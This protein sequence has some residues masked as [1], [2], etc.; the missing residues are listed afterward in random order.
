MRSFH[1][2][3]RLQITAHWTFYDALAVVPYL[4]SLGF[5]SLYLSPILTAKRGS[6]HCYDMTNPLMIN[7]DLGGEEGFRALV[8]AAHAHSMC[9]IVDVVANHMAA[10]IENPWWRDV[11]E[12]GSSSRFSSFFDID[13]KPP[14]QELQGKIL[15]PYL[16]LPF[17][18][19]LEEGGIKMNLREEG[20]CIEAGF[21]RL[22]CNPELYSRILRRSS[23]DKGHYRE[24]EQLF[25]R[26]KKA[27]TNEEKKV[28]AQLIA[29]GKE[30]IAKMVVEHSQEVIE[31]LR[32]INEN[33]T[34]LT[35]FLENQYYRLEYWQT[36][37][38]YINYRR[39]F[40]INELVALRAEENHVFDLC[41]KKLLE[42]CNEGL[43]DGIRVDHPDGLRDPKKYFCRLKEGGCHYL[44]VEKILERNEPLRKDWTVEGT[45]G[46]EYLNTLFGLFV[47]SKS[48]Q[49]MTDL[50]ERFLGEKIDPVQLLIRNKREYA[51]KYMSAEIAAM[52]KKYTPPGVSKEAFILAL[53]DLFAVFPIYRTYI[54]E[55]ETDLLDRKAIQEA[56]EQFQQNSDGIPQKIIHFLEEVFFHGNEPRELLYR[57]QQLSPPIMAKGLEDTHLYQYNRLLSLNEVG[58]SPH[59][60]GFSVDDFHRQ[61]IDGATHFPMRFTTANTHDTKR[62]DD[63]R[64][65][66]ACLSECPAEWEALVLFLSEE[67]SRYS[68]GKRIDKNLEYFFYQTLVGIIPCTPMEVHEELVARVTNYML[69]AAREAKVYT[70]WIN[71]DEN[72]E[73]GLAFFVTSLFTDLSTPFWKRLFP[74]IQKCENAVS[75][76]RISALL[77]RLGSPGVFELYQGTELPFF[78]LVDPDN[79]TPVDYEK[80]RQILE[81]IQHKTHL[82]HEHEKRKLAYLTKFLH[83]RKEHPEL[84]ISGEYMP[85]QCTN[86]SVIGFLR[87]GTKGSCMVLARRFFLSDSHYEGALVHL[88]KEFSQKKWRDLYTKK[89]HSLE[90]PFLVK[91]VIHENPATLLYSYEH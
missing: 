74:F 10:S 5:E 79:R 63:V 53:I 16:P 72:Y 76:S 86:D 85:L 22:P 54:T 15:V 37:F 48:E 59:F 64:L 87:R 73:R 80:R 68:T 45:V 25:D 6:T 38:Q 41:H 4:A 66:I 1:S 7:P 67:A 46:Y 83:F 69:K 62:S 20:I 39:F 8:K 81:E 52:A 60:F 18:Q 27:T 14:H 91:E 56:F 30:Y 9:I 33:K 58:G 88:P 65:R 28:R 12:N 42:L 43:I 31:E 75:Q 40:D 23:L 35:E 71:P 77:L 70:N 47:Y 3:Y 32:E 57:F 34:L 55:K 36:G 89:V 24:V 44:I 50:Y 26:V 61:N 82:P 51:A 11:L 84:F 49:Q 29:Q 19:V 17:H 2:T 21:H 90:A 13:W 78:A